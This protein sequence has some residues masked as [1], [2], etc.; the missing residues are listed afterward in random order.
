MFFT[1][2]METFSLALSSVE[3]TL[4]CITVGIITSLAPYI[5]YT[6]GLM[7][8]ESGTASVIATIEPVVAALISTAVF[9]EPMTLTK[10][11]GIALILSSVVLLK[12]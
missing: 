4:L 3:I 10:I 6:K 8:V 12:E 5:C 7:H 1:N 11:I 2:P 9:A